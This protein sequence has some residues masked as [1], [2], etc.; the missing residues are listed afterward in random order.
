MLF[1]PPGFGYFDY[2][3]LLPKLEK[4][5][6]EIEKFVILEDLGK[7]YELRHESPKFA[8][9]DSFL[10][11]QN[12]PPIPKTKLSPHDLVNVQFTS[13][14]TGLPKSV[15][16]SSYNIMN[17]GRYIWLQTRMKAED[18]ICLPVPLFHSFGMIVGIST[19]AV[20]GSALVL[21]SEVFSASK[22]LECIEK[23]GCTALYGVTTMFIAEM[24][25]KKFASTKRSTLKF[26]IMA[27][28]AMPPEL[29]KRCMK[30]F[31]L[32]RVYTC[33]GMTELSSFVTMM[34]ECDPE[35]KKIN[36]AGRLFPHFILKIVKADTGQV[37]PW[38]EKGEIVASGYGQ[39]SG[40]L[41][42]RQKTAETLRQ[43]SEDLHAGGVGGLGDGTV[44]RKWMHTGDE[45]YLDPDGYLVMTGRIK[46]LVIRGGENISP[47]EI[48]E[49]LCEHAAIE[50]TAVIGVPDDK[51]GETVAAFVELRNG[52]ER[53]SDDAL[54]AW[55]RETMARFKA[56]QYFFW[57]G[58]EDE[59]VPKEWPTTT[60]GKISKPHLRTAVKENEGLL[61]GAG[62]KL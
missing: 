21:P 40:Y 29:L 55:V 24:S 32:P 15:G 46:D 10:N 57:V 41:G 6:P 28:S 36:T 61:K 11:A 45:G 18:R 3:K 51:Y 54:R 31:P 48:E 25:D 23:Y 33:W 17:C 20:A 35:E 62:A 16:L 30:E 8:S 39:M 9:Y 4:E 13:G 14:S 22:A 19:S 42:N 2:T 44:L 56:P 12:L 49:R 53:P 7:K 26:A 47:L 52:A 38:G 34:H 5:I 59:R 43:H 27:G 37:L 1:A 50:Q 58:G 60:S